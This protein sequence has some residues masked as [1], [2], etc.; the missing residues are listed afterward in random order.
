M[1]ID[2]ESAF[3]NEY[4]VKNKRQRYLDFIK[5]PKRRKTFLE[6]LYHGKDLDKGKLKPLIG[7]SETEIAKR[8]EGSQI[9]SC[10]IISV[11]SALDG[12]QMPVKDAL[13]EIV[14]YTEAIVLI[15][16]QCEFIYY[17]GEAPYN[18]YL[19]L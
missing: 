16:G 11:N 17:L 14:A 4:V 7:H 1:N 19:S 10:Y 3:I 2:L 9:T 15:F 5:S 6:M 12:R 8:I 13:A 18:E